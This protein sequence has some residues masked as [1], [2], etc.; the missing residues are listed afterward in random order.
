M[1][2]IACFGRLRELHPGLQLALLGNF[3]DDDPEGLTFYKEVLNAAQK[4]TDV[5]VIKG[6]TDLV[7][8][9]Q[10]LSR[11][12]LQKS[13]REGFGLTVTEALWK[14]TPVVAGNVG[15]IRLQIS[16]GVGG[17]LV[18][19]AEECVS[20]VDHLLTHEEERIALGEAG[21]EHVRLNFL[22]P[23]LLRDELK[24]VRGLLSGTTVSPRISAQA[25]AA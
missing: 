13:L 6:L 9:F 20:K 17:Y 15:G 2:V 7:N 24:L 22:L 19:N 8:P 10:C 4:L 18:D 25:W 14:G 11:V 12:V 21:R 3:A 5:H 1:G 16:D 23:R